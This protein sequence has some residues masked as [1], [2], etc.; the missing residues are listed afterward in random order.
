MPEIVPV[1]GV[2]E[3]PEGLT[4]T[5]A[6]MELALVA[7]M[8]PDVDDMT[9]DVVTGNVADVDPCGTF[10]VAGT[11]A[12][13]LELDRPTKTPPAPAGLARVTVPLAD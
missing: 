11:V 7:V 8:L 5:G 3:L 1:P 4:V 9:G 2:P 12:F 13:G 6:L 10:T